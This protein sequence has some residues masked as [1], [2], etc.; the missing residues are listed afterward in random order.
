LMRWFETIAWLTWLLT[1]GTLKLF[2]NLLTTNGTN[3]PQEFCFYQGT[4]AL[5]SQSKPV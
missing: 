4:T 1:K 3:N 2:L 5:S